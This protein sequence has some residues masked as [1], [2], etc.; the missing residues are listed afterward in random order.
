MAPDTQASPDP[1]SGHVVLW[2]GVLGVLLA[3]G[4]SAQLTA[5]LAIRLEPA[6]FLVILS[7]WMASR[8]G[9]RSRTALWV[10]GILTAVLV[11]IEID[12]AQLYVGFGVDIW[13][14]ALC[15]SAVFGAFPSSRRDA[16]R[17]WAP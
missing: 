11:S 13:L 2:G 9:P 12:A 5:V 10:F 6:C 1:P 15:V 3:F 4:A 17:S 14:T 8:C 7:G 16:F